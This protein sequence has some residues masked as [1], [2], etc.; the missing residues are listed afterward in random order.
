MA[1]LNKFMGI[2]NLGADPDQRYLPS[3]EAVSNFRIA[4]T[5][6]WKDKDG[7][8]QEATEWI[9]IEAFGKLAEICN[10]Y[11]KKGASVY[12]EGSMRT[13]KWQDKDGKD[14]YTT[15]IKCSEMKMLGSKS[16]NSSGSDSPTKATKPAPSGGSFDDFDSD[17]PF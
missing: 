13:R 8:K 3:G 15:S 12:V 2:G 7:N 10:Q 5:N 9:T 14:R 6:T 17:L 1:S 4:C 11:L 16:E